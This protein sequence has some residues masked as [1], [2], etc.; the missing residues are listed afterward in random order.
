MDLD[1][2]KQFLKIDGPEYDI[3]LPIYQQ[4]AEES[5]II[6]G[7]QKDYSKGLYKVLVSIIVGTFIENPTLTTTGSV[8]A[9]SLGVTLVGLIDQYRKSQVV[10]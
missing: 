8:S 2:L 1:E 7:A 4:A 3:V 9:N 6:A 5:L 10:I